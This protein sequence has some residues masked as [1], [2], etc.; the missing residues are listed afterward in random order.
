MGLRRLKNL[1]DQILTFIGSLLKVCGVKGDYNGVWVK[2]KY[3]VKVTLTS[4]T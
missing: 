4:M 3:H 1:K 2:P